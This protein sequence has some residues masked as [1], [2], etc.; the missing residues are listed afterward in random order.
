VSPNQ[1]VTYAVLRDGVILELRVDIQVSGEELLPVYRDMV[2]LHVREHFRETLKTTALDDL[3]SSNQVLNLFLLYFK[4]PESW[5][6]TR[7]RIERIQVVYANPQQPDVVEPEKAEQS[8]G[9]LF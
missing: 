3:L 2:Y 1:Y 5:E 9:M 7:N 8:R 4:N 6:R